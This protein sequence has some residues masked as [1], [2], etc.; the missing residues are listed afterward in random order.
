MAFAG[1]VRFEV[2]RRIGAGGMGVV[3][4]AVDRLRGSRVA[5]K[6]LSDTAPNLLYHLKQEFRALSGMVHP[7]LVTIYELIATEANWLL[8]ME[9]V[10][11]VDFL[12]YFRPRPVPASEATPTASTPTQTLAAASPAGPARNPEGAKVSALTENQYEP[13]RDALRQLTEGVRALH[14]AG[15]LH[16]DLKPSN[17]MITRERRVIILDFGMVIGLMPSPLAPGGS[18]GGTRNYM[19]PEQ[20]T[21]VLL[22]KAADWYAVGVMLYETLSGVLPRFEESGPGERRLIPPCELVAGIPSDLSRLCADLLLHD[23]AG[24]PDGP[25]ILERLSGAAPPAHGSQPPVERGEVFLDRREMES[26]R[27]AFRRLED[28][29]PAEFYLHG[30]S[31]M[32]KSWLAA[33]FLEELSGRGA[34]ILAGRC[35]ERESVPYKA[36]DSVV[37]SLSRYLAK[38]PRNDLAEL[39]PRHTHALGQIFPVLNRVAAIAEAPLARVEFTDQHELRRRAWGALRDLLARLGD[40]QPLCIFIDDLQWGDGDSAALL[41]ELLSPPDPPLLLFLGCYRTEYENTSPCLAGLLTREAAGQK[42]ELGP[43]GYEDARAVAM[44]LLG[45]DGPRAAAIARES[46]GNPYFLNELVRYA[47]ESGA[48][49]RVT[50]P[51]L[52][53]E[54]MLWTRVRELPE[55]PRELL[56][57]LSVA[58]HAVAEALA[59]RAAGMGGE[60]QQTIAMLRAKRLVRASGP[61]QPAEIEPFHDRLRETVAARLEGER[62]REL[63]GRLAAAIEQSDN[64]D[65]E[66]LGMHYQGAGENGAAARYYYAAASQ[67][68]RALAFGHAADL[69]RT[70]LDLDPPAPTVLAAMRGRLGNALANAGRAFEAAQVYRDAAREALPEE[71][72]DL[73]RRSAYQ[74]SISGHVA[75]GHAAFARALGRIGMRL[76][77]TPRQIMAAYLWTYLRL[78]LRGFGFRRREEGELTPMARNR[79][80]TTWAAGTGLALIDVPNGA[81]FTC[82]ALL[83]ALQCGDLNRIARALMWEGVTTH[84]LGNARRGRALMELCRKV[85]ADT[86]SPY[87][88]AILQFGEGVVAFS[89]DFCKAGPLLEEAERHLSEE[90]TGVTWELSNARLFQLYTMMYRGQYRELA[91]RSATLLAEASA[92]GDL[93]TAVIIGCDVQPLVRLTAGDPAG[94]ARAIEEW[95]R[96]WTAPGFFQIHAMAAQQVAWVHLYRGDGASALESLEQHWPDLRANL[97]LRVPWWEASFLETR[98]RSAVAAALHAADPGPLLKAAER[99]VERLDRTTRAFTETCAAAIRA[100][101]AALREDRPQAARWLERTVETA[102]EAGMECHAAAARR[103]LGRIAGQEQAAAEADAWMER[104]GIADRDAMTRMICPGFR[105]VASKQV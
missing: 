100:S 83:V 32:G 92:R 80:D 2:V 49:P 87:A 75:E 86:G 101:L 6:T 17:V 16:R 50:G 73:E 102:E 70:A 30:R 105:E 9:F 62:L 19:A 34:V 88:R 14:A 81:Y 39:L 71:A 15:L 36:L 82:R 22:T 72:D 52:R 103:L 46:G 24:R 93:Y 60:A 11:G 42:I 59:A 28:G 85:V 58:G 35:Y 43:L 18:F 25:E 51:E 96:Q 77:R 4:E 67:A 13:L 97:Y 54:D 64:P 33:K 7:N 65:P 48:G 26:L 45:E 78:S 95:L 55:A 40:R 44:A 56:E 69:Y 91:V 94:A 68:E 89:L 79:A 29:H 27:A 90:C 37:D 84:A 5:L 10:D 3:Y 23:P 99:D 61:A 38:L 47:L 98:A 20:A 74:F 8:T 53:L 57:L 76:P 12:R 41:R 104:Q 31:G 66:L 63:H 21:T 1:D